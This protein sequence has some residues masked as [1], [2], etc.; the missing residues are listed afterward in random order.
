MRFVTEPF[1]APYM[2]RALLAVVL[3][4]VL[5]GAVGV[6]VQL[7]RLT[8]LADALTH[9]V[10]PGVAVAFFAHGS[11]FVGA[12]VAGV[13]SAVLL[14]FATRLVRLDDDAMLALLLA[15]AFSVGVVVVS[16]RPTY[17]ADLTA[18]LFGRVLTVRTGDLAVTAVIAVVALAVLVALRKELVLHAFDPVGARSLGYPVLALD[19]VTN[20]VVAC[21]VVA[22]V[23]AVGT[24]LVVALLVT[25][26]ATARLLVD[27]IAP[28]VALAVG[29]GLLGGWL[30]LVVSFD[31]SVHHQVRLAPGA[32]VV[33]ALTAIFAVT[34]AVRAVV[35]RRRAPAVGRAAEVPA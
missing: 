24:A 12:L 22:A 8:F 26:A 15:T 34:A 27:R 13:L 23:R 20:V 2:Q 14:T 32:T 33:V 18:L 11:I 21:V 1:A 29:F 35:R 4:A 19:L 7:R 5:A 9:T 3:L 6:L 16:R 17:T 25:P 30:G 28:M 31:A 10:F